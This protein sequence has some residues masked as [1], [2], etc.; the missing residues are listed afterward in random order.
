M[1]RYAVYL[2]VLVVLCVG[3]GL[4]A[5]LTIAKNVGGRD[6]LEIQERQD[7]PI[8]SWHGKKMGKEQ[9]CRKKGKQPLQKLAKKLGLNEAQKEQVKEILEDTRKEVGLVA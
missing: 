9:L 7:A 5:G 3:A 6:L 4:I 1:K 2:V 8:R